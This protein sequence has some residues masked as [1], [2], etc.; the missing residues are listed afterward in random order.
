MCEGV[1]YGGLG[2]PLHEG[3]KVKPGLRWRPKDAGDASLGTP[4]KESCRL[5]N[6]KRSWKC[7]IWSLPC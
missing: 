2:R 6:S 1:L 5:D 4:A 7:R 3:V